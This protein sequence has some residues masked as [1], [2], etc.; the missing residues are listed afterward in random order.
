MTILSDCLGQLRNHTYTQT[1]PIGKNLP[2]HDKL[3]WHTH[4]QFLQP[5]CVHSLIP[6]LTAFIPRF[7]NYIPRFTDFAKGNISFNA[8]SSENVILDVFQK[9][10][11]SPVLLEQKHSSVKYSIG[12]YMSHYKKN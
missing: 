10:L 6:R 11:A 9:S 7:T 8:S 4:G 5:R 2:F 12:T 1:V 3:L